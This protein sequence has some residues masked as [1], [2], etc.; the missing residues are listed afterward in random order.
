M[1]LP[2][3]PQGVAEPPKIDRTLLGIG[4]MTLGFLCYSVSDATA[5]F[6]TQEFQPI[7]VAWLRSLGLLSVGLWLI[8]TRGPSILKTVRPALQISRGL[9]AG[10]SATCFIFAVSYVPLADAVAVSFVAPFMVTVLAAL[11]LREPVGIRR[12]TAVTIGFIGT[13]IVIR[14]GLGVFQPAILLVLLAASL[15]AARQILSRGIG[16]ADRTSTT[17]TYTAIGSVT[18]LTIPAAV[19]WQT[20]TSLQQV[21][22][23]MLLACSAGMGEVLIIRALELAQA[24]TLAPLQYTMIVW[25]TSLSWL[26]FSQLPDFWTLVGAAIIM[27]SGIYTLHRE[28]VASHGRRQPQVIRTG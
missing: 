23:I 17:I 19:V 8:V 5:K 15:F 2:Q 4:L 10:L 27:A 13:V 7:Q 9:V 24:A 11:L 1:S 3:A 18:L 21:L 12:W 26:V 25:S 22:L 14:P 16:S 28:R 6:L 20:P